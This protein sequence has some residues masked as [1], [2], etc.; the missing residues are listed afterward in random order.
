V[1]EHLTTLQRDPALP[2]GVRLRSAAITL[3]VPPPR[4]YVRLQIA[5]RHVGDV[6]AIR[7]ADVALPTQAGRCVGDDPAALWMSPEGWLLTSKSVTG[8]GLQAIAQ[9][10]C[11]D[12]SAAAID[13]SDALVAIEL[14]GPRSRELL[15]RGC[16]L[17]LSTR[18][19]GVGQCVRT[20]LAQLAVIV[21]PM[22]EDI[23]ELIVDRGPAAWLCGWIE[24]AATGLDA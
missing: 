2:V 10:A 24:D 1:V 12:F 13:V 15:A 5:R 4:A 22:A 17:D 14:H 19:L 23:V 9:K 20:R 16:G 11:N 3:E 6:G 18:A 7:I 21:R 8:P